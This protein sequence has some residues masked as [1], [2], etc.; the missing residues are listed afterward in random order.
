MKAAGLS[1]L[2]PV[3]G[4]DA[5]LAAIQ[6]ILAGEQYMTVY[7][8]IK[9]EAEGAAVLAYDLLTGKTPDASMT[10]GKV[11]NGK[12]LAGRATD[13]LSLAVV[14]GILYAGVHLAPG[15]QGE[16]SR[17]AALIGA[18]GFLL[19]AGT[20]TSELVEVIGVPHLTGYLFAGIIAGPHVLHLVEHESVKQLEPVNTLAI[21]LIALAGGAELRLDQLKR[22]LRSLVIALGLQTV[23]GMVLMTG[24]FFLARPAFVSGMTSTA[25][26]GVAILWGCLAINV[27]RADRPAA[28]DGRVRRH[29]RA[30]RRYLG[31]FPLFDRRRVRACL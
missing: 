3:T 1:P 10:N 26:L 21:A 2:P 17:D 29:R 20:L 11:A 30:R 15:I 31:R 14:F 23:I 16:W 27:G 8:A 28:R 12:S 13:A 19:L 25:V 5:E 24:V 9:P 6:R 22:G 7:K 18:V 4:Q